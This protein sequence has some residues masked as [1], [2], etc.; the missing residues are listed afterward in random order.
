MSES[1]AINW[2]NKRTDKILVRL[3]MIKNNSFPTCSASSFGYVRA[4]TSTF[5]IHSACSFIFFQVLK[6]QLHTMPWGTPDGFKFKNFKRSRNVILNH[7]QNLSNYKL[8][9]THTSSTYRG[10]G[11]TLDQNR[12]NPKLLTVAMTLRMSDLG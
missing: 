2:S 1:T 8:T 11:P 6:F 3:Y 7:L 5:Q 9:L 10:T 4:S 12:S